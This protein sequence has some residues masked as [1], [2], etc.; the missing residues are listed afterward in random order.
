MRKTLFAVCAA[1]LGGGLVPV[2]AQTLQMTEAPAAQAGASVPGRGLSKAQV[3]ASYG[4]PSEKIAAVG[5]P[6][7]SRWVYPGFIV[8]FEYNHV[9]HAV[10]TPTGR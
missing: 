2:Q 4:A 3:E 8:Y 7:I 5:E 9:V 1:M 10:L 6:P